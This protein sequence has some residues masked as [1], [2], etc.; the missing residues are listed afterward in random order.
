MAHCQ[1]ATNVPRRPIRPKPLTPIPVAMSMVESLA[2]ALRPDPE[3]D[4]AVKPAA[5]P[6]Q[7]AATVSFISDSFMQ[8]MCSWGEEQ[9]QN[10]VLSD[11]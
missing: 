8:S 7:R 4:D 1:L 9:N 5:E 3:K 10:A 6:R 2:V 11:V